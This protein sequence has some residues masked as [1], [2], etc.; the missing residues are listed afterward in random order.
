[1]NK[2]SLRNKSTPVKNL[3]KSKSPTKKEKD[4][5]QRPSPYNLFIMHFSKEYPQYAELSNMNRL[6]EQA[7][8]WKALSESDKDVWRQRSEEIYQQL[9]SNPEKKEEIFNKFRSSKKSE[10]IFLENL[11]ART[12]NTN[13]K[14]K[15]SKSKKAN[16]IESENSENKNTFEVLKIKFSLDEVFPTITRT[17]EIPSNFNFCQLHHCIQDSFDFYD[18][19]AHLF[20]LDDGKGPINSNKEDFYLI[21]NYL[22]N[23]LPHIYY[24]YKNED[25]W[26]IKIEFISK[27]IA[28]EKMDIPLMIDGSYANPPENVGGPEGLTKFIKVMANP[29]DIQYDS[30]NK[31]YMEERIGSDS[32][33]FEFKKFDPKLTTFRKTFIIKEKKV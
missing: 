17:V 20:L 22:S 3:R 4:K 18:T 2:N 15:S 8:I 25:Y 32:S 28:N 9:L 5:I 19:A 26:K 31:W 23:E 6:I 13:K 14:G 10:P 12:E 33:K 16:N 29:N 24:E 30:F 11:D 27:S 21:G 1:M 7:K